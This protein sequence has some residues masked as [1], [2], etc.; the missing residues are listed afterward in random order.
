MEERLGGQTRF[1]KAYDKTNWGFLDFVF[2]G[3]DSD[4]SKWIQDCISTRHFSILI[5]GSPEDFF[6]GTRSVR[7]SDPLSPFL[8]TIVVYSFCQVINKG[9]QKKTDQRVHSWSRRGG[10]LP[11]AVCR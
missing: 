3:R 1:E 10:N 4:Y 9:V 8:S 5:N 2:K 11:L 7:Q 6:Y